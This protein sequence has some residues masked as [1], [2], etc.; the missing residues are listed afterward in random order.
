MKY[1]KYTLTQDIYIIY[2]MGHNEVFQYINPEAFSSK[3]YK[4]E[5]RLLILSH[6]LF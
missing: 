4:I 2:N 3:S 5:W 6:T 1:L